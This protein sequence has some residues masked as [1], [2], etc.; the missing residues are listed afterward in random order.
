MRRVVVFILGNAVTRANP[1]FTEFDIKKPINK[2]QI[3]TTREGLVLIQIVN[4]FLLCNVNIY[5]LLKII[6]KLSI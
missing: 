6:L 1:Y 2:K 4:N 3:A 5:L